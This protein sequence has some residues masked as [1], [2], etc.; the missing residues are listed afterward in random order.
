MDISNNNPRT[1]LASLEIRKMGAM[2][3]K[4]VWDVAK[5][6]LVQIGTEAALKAIDL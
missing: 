3:G 5:E 6:I 2:V 4:E 1:N